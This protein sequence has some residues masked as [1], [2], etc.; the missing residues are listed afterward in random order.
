MN[1]V[2]TH[3]FGQDFVRKLHERKTIEH[4]L[5]RLATLH[6]KNMKHNIYLTKAQRLRNEVSKNNLDRMYLED[7]EHAYLEKNRIP[8]L[9]SSSLLKQDKASPRS[10]STRD[11]HGEQTK[12]PPIKRPGEEQETEIR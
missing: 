10:Y 6:Q 8:K 11:L 12:L 2:M 4:E 7:M 3:E 5:D 9:L 1:M